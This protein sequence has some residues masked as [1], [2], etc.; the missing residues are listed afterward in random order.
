MLKSNVNYVVPPAGYIPQKCGVRCTRQGTLYPTH[1]ARW[2]RPWYYTAMRVSRLI[3]DDGLI[4]TF[5]ATPSRLLE[6]DGSC[7]ALWRKSQRQAPQPPGTEPRRRR[8]Q[9]ACLCR[10]RLAKPFS[11]RK[12]Y[13]PARIRRGFRLGFLSRSRAPLR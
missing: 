12:H 2:R 11:Q 7:S 1:T 10:R 13:Y 3:D 5:L 9:K 6:H 4:L 8:L